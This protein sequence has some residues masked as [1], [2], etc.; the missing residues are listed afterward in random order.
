MYLRQLANSIQWSN[1]ILFDAVFVHALPHMQMF[2]NEHRAAQ[3]L[4]CWMDIEAFRGIPARNKHLRNL[5]AQQLR[6]KYFTRKY[7]L[8]PDSPASKE[9]QRQVWTYP[10]TGTC[11]NAYTLSKDKVEE[12]DNTNERTHLYSEYVLC[13]IEQL[14][15]GVYLDLHLATCMCIY[16]AKVSKE[17]KSTTCY[18]HFR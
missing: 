15:R 6:E 4:M 10:P 12:D 18:I 17:Q 7:L 3:H 13:K 2:L 11:K 1:A 5:R 16:I 14:L 8:G 9:A